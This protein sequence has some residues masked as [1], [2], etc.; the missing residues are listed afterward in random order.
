[1][2]KKS[3]EKVNTFGLKMLFEVKGFMEDKKGVTAI[4]YAL[5]AVAI[6]SM[7]FLVLGNPEEGGLVNKIKEAFQAIQDGLT[8]SSKSSGK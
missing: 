2:F 7:L 6:S 5:I 4:E 8:V 3:L 1:M